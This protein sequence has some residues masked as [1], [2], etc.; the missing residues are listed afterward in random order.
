MKKL[1]FTLAFLF[2][3]SYSYSQVSIQECGNIVATGLSV[4]N[5]NNPDRNHD[6]FIFRHD[7][8][9]GYNIKLQDNPGS[10]NGKPII[11][12][13]HIEK[14]R[15]KIWFDS[16]YPSNNN[17]NTGEYLNG[18]GRNIYPNSTPQ[19]TLNP[20]LGSNVYALTTTYDMSFL[21][22]PNDIDFFLG[23][24][25]NF[26][27]NEVFR[28]IR[29][30]VYIYVKPEFAHLYPGG[31][32]NRVYQMSSGLFNS[33]TVFTDSDGNNYRTTAFSESPD[34]DGDGLLNEIDLCPED[35]D[36]SNADT[37]DDGDGDVCDNCPNVANSNQLDTDD[38][39]IGNV[40]DDDDDNDGILDINDKCPL[41]ASSNNLDTDLD[42]V[43]DICDNCINEANANQQ[44]MDTDG[45]GDVCDADRDGD[46]ISNTEDNCPDEYGILSNNGCPGLPDL[47]VDVSGSNTVVP[48][49]GNATTS[50]SSSI[51]EQ[52]YT[53]DEIQFNL[54]IKNEGIGDSGNF[55]VGFYLSTDNNIS[56]STLLLDEQFYNINENSSASQNIA[57]S[58]WHFA[59]LLGILDN[60]Y[61]HIKVDI[62]NDVDEG[63]NESNNSFSSRRV[64]IH[65]TAGR[66]AYLNLGNNILVEVRL[67]QYFPSNNRIRPTQTRYNLK[68]YKFDTLDL[69]TNMS[70]VDGTNVNLSNLPYGKYIVHIN[71]NYIKQFKKLTSGIIIPN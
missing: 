55:K 5:I 20:S 2:L 22:H 71:D 42:G 39:G 4:P 26:P 32:N 12:R 33:D 28:N 63:S 19:F 53:G 9:T 14:I 27:S 23:G 66:F 6:G 21:F 65:N 8:V 50:L 16:S 47:V 10:I 25:N 35:F 68:I 36:P 69:I 44:D 46:G 13:N 11:I 18:Y 60:A 67:D 24:S 40:C 41:I 62:D 70:V 31:V 29:F 37:D 43:G 49:S 61:I 3:I 7:L 54:K 17:I 51:I 58:H 1:K 15:D 57:I 52:I 56:N 38:D 34:I 48:G 59:N 64:Y 30:T 45:I